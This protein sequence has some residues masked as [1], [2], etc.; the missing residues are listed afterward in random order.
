MRVVKS[1]PR[2]ARRVVQQVEPAAVAEQAQPAHVVR[3]R[4][5][6]STVEASSSAARA[7][8]VTQGITTVEAVEAGTADADVVGPS[9]PS[10]L[11]EARRRAREGLLAGSVRLPSRLLD[12]DVLEARAEGAEAVQAV[13]A[14]RRKRKRRRPAPPARS[15]DQRELLRQLK[16][17]ARR[18]QRLQ[19]QLEAVHA[20]RSALYREGREQGL[21]LA[22]MARATGV[23]PEYV[24]KVVQGVRR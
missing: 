4:E 11:V 15:D 24:L 1:T 14:A 3:E 9:S 5:D 18:M 20:E 8:V 12:P 10:M 6:S 23:V 13:V 2:R 7:D 19:A 21:T 16:L 17:R 22:E